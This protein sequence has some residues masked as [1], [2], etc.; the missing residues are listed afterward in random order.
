MRV[1]TTAEVRTRLVLTEVDFHSP[2]KIP[3]V[4]FKAIGMKDNVRVRDLWERKDLGRFHGHY[5]AQVP[6][7]G[8]VLLKLQ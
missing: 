8:V 5:T 7:H 4:R 6:R 1:N 2:D 3:T